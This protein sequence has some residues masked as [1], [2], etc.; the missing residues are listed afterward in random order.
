M[1]IRE[2]LKRF[3]FM[4]H[5]ATFHEL[6]VTFYPRLSFACVFLL[7]FFFSGVTTGEILLLD[8]WRCKQVDSSLRQ[9]DLVR[10][11]DSQRWVS[12]NPVVHHHSCLNDLN[13]SKL[14]LYHVKKPIFRHEIAG[15]IT[16]SRSYSP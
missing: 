6:C 7:F 13:Y 10:S 11:V 5:L 14:W 9:V 4:L 16:I 8:M 15:D 12:Q 1:N 2:H 3:D